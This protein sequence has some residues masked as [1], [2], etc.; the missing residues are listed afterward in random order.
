MTTRTSFDGSCRRIS[1]YVLALFVQSASPFPSSVHLCSLFVKDLSLSSPAAV[2]RPPAALFNFT[3]T[4]RCGR[5][6]FLPLRPAIPQQRRGGQGGRA[7]SK[8]LPT[9]KPAVVAITVLND[10]AR[11]RVNATMTCW[12]YP[13]QLRS[14]SP[15]KGVRLRVSPLNLQKICI[16]PFEVDSK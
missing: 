2:A 6:T 8:W 12:Y 10:E 5:L 1:I 15:V 16:L 4:W 3:S 13:M 14:R 7:E 11:E 9:R